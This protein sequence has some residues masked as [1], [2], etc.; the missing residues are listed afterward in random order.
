MRI[1]RSVNQKSDEH[2]ATIGV[3][4]IEIKSLADWN[5]K[6]QCQKESKLDRVHE[7]R[8]LPAQYAKLK[9]VLAS[10]ARK[11]RAA[12]SETED[13]TEARVSEVLHW[14]RLA[15]KTDRVR[16]VHNS[17]FDK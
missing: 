9:R 12:T 11:K 1:S 3:C 5:E 16:F 14:D 17:A 2:E 13:R 15:S 8:K 4:G 10:R 7:E 6:F